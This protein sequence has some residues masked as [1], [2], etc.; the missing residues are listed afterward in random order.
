MTATSTPDEDAI[1]SRSITYKLLNFG[2]YF[3]RLINDEE[4]R[5]WIERVGRSSNVYLV[6][7]IHILANELDPTRVA[8]HDLSPGDRIIGVQYRRIHVRSFNSSKVDAARLDKTSCW[9]IYDLKARRSG[10]GDSLEA[11]L[12]S[13]SLDELEDEYE[14]DMYCGADLDSKYVLFVCAFLGVANLTE[15]R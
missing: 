13:T 7:A 6:V 15:G 2:S 4:T 10:E 5:R 11:E 3:K 9:K 14:F 12:S 1:A 8:S